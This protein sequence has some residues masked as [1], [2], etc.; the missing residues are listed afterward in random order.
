MVVP[1]KSRP[2]PLPPQ[3]GAHGGAALASL[4]IE[5]VQRLPRYQ[6]LLRELLKTTPPGSEA[7][8]SLKAGIAAVEEVKDWHVLATADSPPRRKFPHWRAVRNTH[9]LTPQ[10]CWHTQPRTGTQEHTIGRLQQSY[11]SRCAKVWGGGEGCGGRRP[12]IPATAPR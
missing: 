10:R 7:A 11:L 5:P 1:E 8:A 4:L 12:G 6:L 2:L 3:V 9:W